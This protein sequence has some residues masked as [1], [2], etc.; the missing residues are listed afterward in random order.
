[1]KTLTKQQTPEP[2][3][4][5]RCDACKEIKTRGDFDKSTVGGRVACCKVCTR[6]GKEKQCGFCRSWK[7]RSELTERKISKY[8]IY[9]LCI[10]CVEKYDAW[11]NKKKR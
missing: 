7:L 8:V 5:K 2:K 6:V 11:K 4:V 1:M 9:F 10:E 3:L